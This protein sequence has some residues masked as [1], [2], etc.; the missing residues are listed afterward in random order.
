MRKFVTVWQRCTT[1]ELC[2]LSAEGPVGIPVVP[3]IWEGTPCAAL[4][5]AHLDLVETLTGSTAAFSVTEGAALAED[6]PAAVASGGVEL[7]YDVEGELFAEHLV[8]QECVKHP[9]TRLRADSLM[10][11][12]ENWWWMPRIIVSLA[13]PYEER[14]VPARR[15]P[16]DALLVRSADH[17]PRVEVVTAEQWPEGGGSEVELWARDGRALQGRGDAAFVFGHRHSPDFERWERWYRSGTLTGDT[18]AVAE[19][20]GDPETE[21]APF[22]ML[23]R[24]RNHREVERACRAGIARVEKRGGREA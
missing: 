24:L 17:R 15:H 11:R 8:E 13:E 1:A 21:P 7:R 4:P 14:E 5:F 9:P 2:W 12:R 6:V 23:A 19:A 10:A 20:A 22:S 3:L 16:A 18:L